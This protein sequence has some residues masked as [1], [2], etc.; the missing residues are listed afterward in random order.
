LCWAWIIHGLLTGDKEVKILIL[1]DIHFPYHNQK[2]LDEAV[3]A[4]KHEKPSHVVQIGD[5]YDQYGF[6]NYSNRTGTDQQKE[7]REAR[8]LGVDL[9]KNI[10]NLRP[11][12][13]AF[14]ILGNHDLRATKRAQERLPGSM[15]A[16][17]D[18]MLSHYRFKGVTTIE[19]DRHILKIGNVS[20]HHG[21]LSKPGDHMRAFKSS[22]V[23][24]HSHVGGVV[25]SVLSG[26]QQFEL[27]AGFL[28]DETS[29]PLMY[30][31]AKTEKWT[32][33][34]GL[35]TIGSKITRAEYI[36]VSK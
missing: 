25:R 13:K 30:N 23:V 3:Y 34:Y 36:P 11:G 24:G 19:D 12:V 5:L 26:E 16:V 27:N 29:E 22:T 2:A 15:Q 31:P 17:H 10:R 32:H 1:G 20:F 33:G 28:A 7:L 18:F 6:S 35:V 14:Q 4:V 21:Y 8:L 9:W